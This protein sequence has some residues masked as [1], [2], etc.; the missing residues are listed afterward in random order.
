MKPERQML[1]IVAKRM[2]KNWQDYRWDVMLNLD[3]PV[4]SQMLRDQIFGKFRAY[5]EDCNL[6]NELKKVSHGK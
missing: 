3:A 5:V 6:Y 2:R 4:Y 1:L